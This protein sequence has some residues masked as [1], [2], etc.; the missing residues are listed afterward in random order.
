M[1]VQLK[2]NRPDPDQ[3]A[4]LTPGNRYRVL[5]IEANDLRLLNDEGQPYLYP[6]QLFI[7]VDP[8]EPPDW[9][10]TYG[11]EGERY[12]YPPALSRPGFFEDYFDGNAE[13]KAA[14][15]QYLA[16]SRTTVAPTPAA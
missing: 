6:P 14:L 5:G 1:Q 8:T 2:P 16:E 3:Y 12:A 13:A 11:D 4:D 10:T 7:I 15:R 9:V